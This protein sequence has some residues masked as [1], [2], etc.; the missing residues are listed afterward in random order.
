MKQ[1]ISFIILSIVMVLSA[2]YCNAFA[3]DNRIKVGYYIASQYQEVD[4]NNEYSGYAYEYYQEIA[5]Y[6]GWNY[7]FVV[8][9]F[10][11]CVE[12]LEKGEIDL[13]SGVDMTSERAKYVDFSDFTFGSSKVGIYALEDNEKL[14]FEDFNS[15]NNINIGVLQGDK[16]INSLYKYREKHNFTINVKNFCSQEEMEKALLNKDVDAIFLSNE[17]EL[18]NVKLVG[19]IDSVPLYFASNKAKPEIMKRLNEAIREIRNYNPFFENDMYK[20]YGYSQDIAAPTFTRE[21]LEYIRSNP[22]I[23]VVYDPMYA[24]IE[25]YNQKT[26]EYCGISQGILQQVEKYSGLTFE[27]IKPK[28]FSDAVSTISK[29]KADIV[30]SISRDYN[31]AN[32]NNVN[33]SS[34]YL[35][36]PVVILARN[37]I[38][39]DNIKTIAL[40]KGYYTTYCVEKKKDL[41]KFIYYSTVE[42]CLQAVE[43]G[44]ADATYVNIYVASYFLSTSKIKSIYSA[45]VS[46]ISENLSLGISKSSNEHLLSII[47]KAL[48]C[49]QT[50]EKKHIVLDNTIYSNNITFEK[51]MKIHKTQAIGATTMGVIFAI[52]I[53]I[54]ILI[55]NRR[56]N[57]KI[58]DALTQTNLC[59]E[60]FKMAL[61]QVKSQIFEYDIKTKRLFVIDKD[62]G[63]GIEI[64]DNLEELPY[65]VLRYGIIDEEFIQTYKLMFEHIS[66]NQKA[67]TEILRLGIEN[68]D[69]KWRRLT[70]ATVFDENVPLRIIGV[71]EN[72]TQEKRIENRFY[73]E[74]QYR[75]AML[76][77]AL[78]VLSINVT[79]N[80]VI[81][82]VVGEREI[83]SK[84]DNVSFNI[85]IFADNGIDIDPEDL[86]KTKEIYK[87]KNLTEAFENGRRELSMSLRCKTHSD[88]YSWINSTANLLADP[89][90]GDILCFIYA[91]DINE[92]KKIE[93]QL[94]HKAERDSLTGLYN[95][96]MAESFITQSLKECEGSRSAFLMLDL[97]DF[98]NINDKH[99]HYAGDFVLCSIAD[100]LKA[101]FRSDDIVARMGGDEFCVF[102]ERIPS[103]K[104]L[105]KKAEEIAEEFEHIAYKGIKENTISMSIGIA[106]CPEHGNTFLELYKKADVALYQAKSLGKNRASIYSDEK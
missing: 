55:S 46:D 15:F 92:Q 69:D 26:G 95:R 8:A 39:R 106:I 87:V 100:V 25:Y 35:E 63:E 57:C 53:I 101:S 24:P 58:K 30:A 74:Q 80:K 3:D 82:F 61:L 29:G 76:S 96:V 2:F 67:S 48:L 85:G 38:N 14:V 86:E 52:I 44:K 54:G 1:K 27:Y 56:K 89:D 94:K 34:A 11:E 19:I 64:T 78:G 93:F 65:Q 49:I 77:E 22:K 60:R 70:F 72:I 10:S 79:K 23:T 42:E 97:D 102:I 59:N 32:K 73:M 43:E 66:P 103:E 41:G 62:S 83:I 7:K 51:F 40:P 98:K 36:A 90:T 88:E 28:N 16:Q 81:S 105:I 5:Q 12:M 17:A 71:A 13:M 6:T 75:T 45:G 104:F 21:E 37:G 50:D 91:K 31:W 4:E 9:P 84:A 99:G 33:L 47:N 68:G 20:K 18:K